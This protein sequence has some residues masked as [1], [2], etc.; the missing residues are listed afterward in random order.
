LP[1]IIRPELELKG[2]QVMIYYDILNYQE[3]DLFNVD[4]GITDRE[5]RRITAKALKG[6]I[7]RDI[8]GGR[9]KVIVWSPVEDG[10]ELVGGIYVQV[11]AEVMRSEKENVTTPAKSREQR[12]ST[13]AIVAQS[14]IL[15]GLGLSRETGQPH[16]IRGVAAYGC[17]AG[18]IALNRMANTNYTLYKEENDPS[19]RDEFF[20]KAESQ[21]MT[22]EILAYTAAGIWVTDIIW[23]ILACNTM[24]KAS[25]GQKRRLK[26]VPEYHAD[27]RAP[28]LALYVRF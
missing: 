3:D 21:D 28:M 9:G 20:N 23:N 18:S 4:V 5:D 16:W 11:I 14:L 27:C 1:R 17:L 13:G 25:L 12:V 6:D 22:S 19:A 8:A 26:L 15:P 7:G 24:N 2:D 10:I